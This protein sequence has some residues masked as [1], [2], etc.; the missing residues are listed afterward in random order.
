[1]SGNTV[2]LLHVVYATLSAMAVMVIASLVMGRSFWKN[3]VS[4]SIG[5]AFLLVLH[6]LGGKAAAWAMILLVVMVV[7]GLVSA[8]MS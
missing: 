5:F 4:F 8:A 6:A 1:M 3:A 7:L 2:S